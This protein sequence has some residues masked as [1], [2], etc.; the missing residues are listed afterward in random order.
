[1]PDFPTALA[2]ALQ[3]RYRLERELGRGGMAVVYL[4]TDLRHERP[5]ALKVLLPELAAALGP[6][7][8]Q[9]EIKLA[10]RLQ[11]SH[12]LGVHDSGESAGRLWFTMPF[13]EG[14]S[15][16]DRLRRERQLP[17]DD[18]L[19]LAREAAAAL[20]YA[21]RH[22]VVHRDIK[23]E[24][25]L[26]TSEG[27]TLV[28]DF[29]IA[30][31]LASDDEKLTQTGL[32]VGTP[33]YMSPEQAAGDKALDARTDV[34]SLG[35]VV[36]EMLAGEPPFAGPTPQ[37]IVMKRLTQAPPSI[38]QLRPTVS[39]A[40]D[41]AIRRALAPVPADRFATAAEFGRALH[42]AT[43]TTGA[44]PSPAP[45]VA[46]ATTVITPPPAPAGARPRRRVP[47][48][49]LALGLGFLLGLGVLFAWRRSHADA[50]ETGGKV[51]AVLP[52]ENLGDSAD[53]YFADGVADEVRGKLARIEGLSVIARSSSDEYRN[54]GKRSEDIARELGADYLLVARV[55]WSKAAG[56]PSQ[57]R[58][59]PE[60]VDVRPGHSARTRWQEPFDAALTDVFK[61]QA[62]IA[63]KVA[64]ALDLTLGDTTRRQL[65][66]SPTTN[67][68]AYDVYLQGLALN[69]GAYDIPTIRRTIALFEQA[70]ALDSGFVAAWS[71]LAR[72]RSFLYGS[73]ASRSP[74]MASAALEATERTRALAPNSPEAFLALR[75]YYAN[76]LGD[77]ER[78]LAA[79]EEGL[80]RDPNNVDLLAGAAGE[81]VAQGRL[82]VGL[83]R[84]Q[85]AV[86]LDP[87]SAP[88]L[89]SLAGV[90]RLLR[91][92]SE[93]GAILD[94][95]LQIN[96]SSLGIRQVR[97]TTWLRQGDVAAAKRVLEEAP[98]DVSRA[99]LAAFASL[100][101]DL[102]WLLSDSLQ[103]LVLTLPP[104]AFEDDR[105]YWAMV[106]AQIYKM[107]GQEP[108]A[109][110]FADTA[111]MEFAAP[112][113]PLSPDGQD[114]AVHGL[115]LAYLGRK[116]EAIAMA[117]R[118]VEKGMSLPEAE[119][120]NR[121]QLVRIYL[122]TGETEPALDELEVI[123]R[124]PRLYNPGWWL[125]VDPNL[126]SLKGN[127]RF[128]KLVAGS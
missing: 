112:L 122:L 125:R 120:Y 42:P 111:R 56:A 93:S 61:V 29:G 69:N 28:A 4:A 53:A 48:A 9:R 99:E 79:A 40:V 10:A 21:H 88:R 85:R 32:S 46:A 45:S 6:E 110:A 26:L 114:E 54:S 43:T 103:R 83:E 18:A 115:A 127:P 105:G 126:A 41:E 51:V 101:G 11:H 17:V 37:A 81:H 123:A 75:G 119:V 55:R 95:A 34:Y 52:F 58:V 109:R 82:E 87:R 71:Q 15:L 89:V 25:I 90:L 33:A 23:P 30:R 36:Y 22:G 12:I 72:S 128:E 70:V 63:E 78:A 24:N 91:R 60:L 3:D 49:A 5:V 104:S 84:Y 121:L 73:V 35:A 39:E 97:A 38:R 96:P 27:E 44:T 2:T 77:R 57:V 19:R 113:R 7:R 62:E 94:R 102:Y 14:E 118:G 80:K 16:R 31:A 107:H 74:A 108:L 106:R 59:T 13:V 117:K 8:F 124:G 20:D 100:Y 68:T 86:A 1:M 50:G 76:V 98:P 92:Y 116:A 64:S 47:V 66:A 65:G 67:T